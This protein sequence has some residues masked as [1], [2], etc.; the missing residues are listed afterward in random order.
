[1]MRGVTK[2]RVL[3]LLNLVI[4]GQIQIC[5]T[6][7]NDCE[8]PSS[9]KSVKS[10]TSVYDVRQFCSATEKEQKTPD[11]F[12]DIFRTRCKN[13][14]NECEMSNGKDCDELWNTFFRAFAYKKPCIEKNEYE[15]YCNEAKHEVPYGKTLFY[16][17]DGPYDESHDVK[18]PYVTL[19]HTLTG[20]VLDRIVAWC[21]K[22]EDPGINYDECP[23]RNACHHPDPESNA[24][25]A[26]WQQASIEFAKLATGDVRVLLDGAKED[27]EKAFHSKSYFKLYELP[28]LNKD[29]VKT[30]HILVMYSTKNIIETC[31]TGSIKELQIN[32]SKTFKHGS[33]WDSTPWMNMVAEEQSKT[34]LTVT[35]LAP[36]LLSD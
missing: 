15:T 23:D 31:G 7:R 32:I 29:N 21:G 36:L 14:I 28:N 9:V 35:F 22:P 1:M 13:H 16:S 4:N 33:T 2:M 19:E 30:I 20:N 25:C 10:V 11:N 6:R 5:T 3:L 24:K 12:E 8:F 17:G 34:L 26:F 18:I 27:G